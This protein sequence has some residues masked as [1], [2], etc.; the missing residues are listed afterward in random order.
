[1]ALYLQRSCHNQNI[2]LYAVDGTIKF[3]A[4]FSGDPNETDA[5]DKYTDATFDVWV[6]DPR[7]AGLGHPADAIPRELLSRVTGGFRFYFERGQPGQPF[8]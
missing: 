8:P 6:G 5:V 7:D 1:M 2:V 4:L 3:Q